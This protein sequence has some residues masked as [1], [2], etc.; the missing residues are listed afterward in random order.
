MT[1]Q[2]TLTVER[3]GDSVGEVSVA[4]ATEDL[5]AKAG[6][7]YSEDSGVLTF[8]AGETTKEI[9]VMLAGKA[10]TAER[11]FIVALK[12]PTGGALL[13]SVDRAAVTI[14]ARAGGLLLPLLSR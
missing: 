11:N 1:G 10:S 7:D 4:Y 6:E 2:V 13:S 9:T 5:T 3:S 8:A 12:E 14:E